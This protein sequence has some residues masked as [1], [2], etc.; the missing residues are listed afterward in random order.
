MSKLA[1][2]LA[3]LLVPA[4]LVAGVIATPA[5]AQ[6]KMA[7]KK[8]EKAASKPTIKEI[9][10]NDKVRVYEAIYKPGDESASVEQ[11]PRV[12]RAL[13]GGTLTRI[14][15]DGKKEKSA[16]KN[17]DAKVFGATPAYAVKNEGKS[18]IHLYVLEVK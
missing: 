8:M 15:P 3:G 4:F 11:P 14:Y 2:V 1:S 7:A 16:Y 6:E 10:K 9:A 17:G 18:A 5:M 12:V 13:K